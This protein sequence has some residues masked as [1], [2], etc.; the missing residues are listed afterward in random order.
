MTEQQPMKMAAAEALYKTVE[1]GVVLDLHDRQPRRPQRGLSLRIPDGLSFLATDHPERRV[2]GIN[3][4][5]QRVR[6]Q[7]R[8]RRLQAQHRR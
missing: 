3:D 7:I 2:E 4:V 5:Q 6:Q 8:A 1:P